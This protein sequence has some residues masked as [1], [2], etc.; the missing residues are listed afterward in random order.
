MLL[1]TS[2]RRAARKNKLFGEDERGVV[3]MTIIIKLIIG[4]GVVLSCFV[5][6]PSV[7]CVIGLGFRFFRCLIWFVRL[8]TGVRFLIF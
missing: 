7:C 6:C 8:R 5:V 1:L 4:K 3:F 2:T